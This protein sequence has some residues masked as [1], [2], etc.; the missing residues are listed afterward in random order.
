MSKTIADIGKKVLLID[1][2][3]RKPQ[4][5]KRLGINNTTGLSNYLSDTNRIKR[6]S[7]EY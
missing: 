5:H 3:M 7:S 1:A 6:C 2:D 4:I